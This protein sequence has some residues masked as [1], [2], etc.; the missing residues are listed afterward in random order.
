VLVSALSTYGGLLKDGALAKVSAFV[1]A[2]AVRRTNKRFIAVTCHY[3]VL[4]WLEPDWVFY[5]DD[6][7]FIKKNG[8]RKLKSQSTLALTAF[9]G[10]LG[11][12]T[13]EHRP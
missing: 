9:G 11:T 10:S 8:D 3:D 12:I 4:D 13:I 6:M 1:I 7:S 5:T 2:K